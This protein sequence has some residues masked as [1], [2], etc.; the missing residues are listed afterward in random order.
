MLSLSKDNM[1]KNM[2]NVQ[3][4]RQ[5]RQWRQKCDEVVVKRNSRL[6]TLIFSPISQLGGMLCCSKQEFYFTLMQNL[7]VFREAHMSEERQTLSITGG[8]FCTFGAIS[9]PNFLCNFALFRTLIESKH[10]MSPSL[11]PSL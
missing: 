2:T 6:S 7:A 9:V 8:L 5:S 3:I 1:G 4:L 11:H 10:F